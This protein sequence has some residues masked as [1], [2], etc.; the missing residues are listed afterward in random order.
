M[1]LFA[2]KIA[3]DVE[4]SMYVDCQSTLCLILNNCWRITVQIIA[5]AKESYASHLEMQN[6]RSIFV[7]LCVCMC[8]LKILVLS[9]YHNL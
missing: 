9:E 4:S 5:N 1:N 8:F 3:T 2:A 7:V 6:S